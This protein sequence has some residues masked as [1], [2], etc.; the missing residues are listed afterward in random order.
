MNMLFGFSPGKRYMFD[1]GYGL[2]VI[3]H[4]YGSE[5]G[6]KEA[7]L[8][9]ANGNLIYAD[10]TK[11]GRELPFSDVVGWLTEAQVN[12]LI[13]LVKGLEPDSINA[14]DA[15]EQFQAMLKDRTQ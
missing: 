15:L 11:D 9:N 4:G 7:A 8:L 12:E 14:I 3:S 2:S 13:E 6:L 1:N 5:Q 10:S